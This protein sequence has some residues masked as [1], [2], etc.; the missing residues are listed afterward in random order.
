MY[1]KYYS[2]LWLAC[3][4]MVAV[5]AVFRLVITL[6]REIL[7]PRIHFWPKKR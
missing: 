1:Q 3:V 7:T 2:A 6:Q 5:L 4:K